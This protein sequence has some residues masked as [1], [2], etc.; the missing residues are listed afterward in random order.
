M[1]TK[2]PE[3]IESLRASCSGNGIVIVKGCNVHNG[4]VFRRVRVI[5]EVQAR[6][7]IFSVYCNIYYLT[8]DFARLDRGLKMS[9]SDGLA[10]PTF[11]AYDR[12]AV[13]G[14]VLNYISPLW[15]PQSNCGGNSP[16]IMIA[17]PERPQDGVS[18]LFLGFLL[19]YFLEIAIY[20]AQRASSVM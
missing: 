20:P 7:V 9:L 6:L 1:S 3:V 17:I 5:H 13:V 11:L 14:G 4:R 8:P 12:E 18:E 15:I 16:R 19:G 10:P 2:I